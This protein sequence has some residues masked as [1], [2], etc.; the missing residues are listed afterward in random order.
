MKL[1]DQKSE[2]WSYYK[3]VFCL[4]RATCMSYKNIECCPDKIGYTRVY[5]MPW[6]E[7]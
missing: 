2:I 6:T 1:Y 5:D 4:I 7:T 3:E